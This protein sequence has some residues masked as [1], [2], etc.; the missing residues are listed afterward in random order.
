VCGDDGCGGSSCGTCPDGQQCDGAGKCIC[1]PVGPDLIVLPICGGICVDTN[2]DP[3]N[4]GGCGNTCPVWDSGQVGCND[5]TCCNL[6]GAN[7]PCRNDD[8]CCPST[9]GPGTAVT[10]FNGRCVESGNPG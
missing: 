6:G 1:S 4:C 8:D 7:Q 3:T 5:G 9:D 2:T 10:C